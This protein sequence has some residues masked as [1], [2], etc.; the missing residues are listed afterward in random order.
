MQKNTSELFCDLVYVPAGASPLVYSIPW[1]PQTTVADIL[2]TSKIQQTHPETDTLAVGIFG[3][4]VQR[5]TPVKPGDRIELYRP[6]LID[7]KEKRRQ[8]AKH[9]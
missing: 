6:L 3:R 2:N 7:P 9:K 8:I 1:S 5:D 4:C